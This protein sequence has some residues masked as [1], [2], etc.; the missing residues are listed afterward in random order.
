MFKRHFLQATVAAVALATL[1]TAQAQNKPVKF[2]LD[3]RFEGPRLC[4]CNRH[5]R[6]IT[7]MRAWT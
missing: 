4:S 3:W 5:P 2:Q 6:A 1:G 7:R